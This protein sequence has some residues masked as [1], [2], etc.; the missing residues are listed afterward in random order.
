MHPFAFQSRKLIS[1]AIIFQLLHKTEQEQFAAFFEHDG[2]AAELNVGLDLV[3]FREKVFGMAQFEL[4]IVFAGFRSETDFL[5]FNLDRVGFEL[6]FAFFLLVEELIVVHNTHN[7]RSGIGSDLYQIQAGIFSPAQKSGCWIDAC[8]HGLTNS[9]A[10]FLE[11]VAY[12][13]YLGGS[14]E[15]VDIVFWAAL[16]AVEGTGASRTATWAG[17]AAWA[18]GPGAAWRFRLVRFERQLYGTVWCK[19]EWP[20]NDGQDHL[21]Q[22]QLQK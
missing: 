3:A 17:R 11:I 9:F 15:M 8:F 4:K 10:D 13:A 22:R 2:S 18:R 7:R 16:T 14:N 12:K 21:F 20:A 19:N 5:E 1:A 6:F